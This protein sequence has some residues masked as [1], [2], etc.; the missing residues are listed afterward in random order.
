[1]SITIRAAQRGDLA[2]LADFNVA[3]A[4]ETEGKTLDRATLTRGIAGVFDEPRRGFYLCAVDGG[5]VVGGLLVTYEWSDWRDGDWWWIQSVFVRQ[6][7]RRQ[8]V[9]RALHGEVERLA[10]AAPHVVGLRLYVE[11]ENLRAQSTYRTL[12]MRQS[13]YRM[14]E[15]PFV[16]IA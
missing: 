3:M 11:N 2:A 14:F 1:M 12:G 6:T 8:G 15:Q 4:L 10:R 5:T 13:A 7:H 16:A 9:Y